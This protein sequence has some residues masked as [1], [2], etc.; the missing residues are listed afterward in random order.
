MKI[1]F[2]GR[3]RDPDECGVSPLDHGL[4]Y[5]DGVFEGIR[6]SAGAVFRLDDHLKRLALSARCIGLELPLAPGR[7]REI[8]LET[9]RAVG[10]TEA[11]V[12]LLV[13]RGEG[14]LG[15]DPTDCNEPQLICIVGAINMF[16]EERRRA[17]LRLMTA[18]QRRPA[19]DVLDPQ[20]KSLNYLNNVLAKREA[21]LCGY[22]DAILLNHSGAVTEASGANLFVVK[23]GC[24]L[25]P[26]PSDGALPGIT[27]NSVFAI[28]EAMDIECREQTLTRY[29]VIAAEEVFLTGSGAGI[30]AAQSLDDLAIGDGARRMTAM[31]CNEFSSYAR[32]HGIAFAA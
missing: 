30:V 23:H 19:A 26:G 11:Y 31:I 8:V 29:D 10:A 15:I 27:R 12:R 17:G 22:D 6:I 7:I 4:L 18:S 24:L 25:T 28:A 14:Q 3:V 13:T 1:W 5:G 32:H 21:R 2:K 16:C 20:V 9:A